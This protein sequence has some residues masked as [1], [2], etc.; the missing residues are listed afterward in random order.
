[1]RVLVCGGRD[2]NDTLMVYRTLDLIHRANMIDVLIEGNA[3]GADRMG[4]YW[5][6]KNRVDNLKFPA[7]WKAHGRAAGPIRN[8]KMLAEG[9]PDLV[10]AFPG[11]KGTADMKRQAIA[12]GVEVLEITDA[13]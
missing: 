9:E 1:L 5:A 6:R 11:G 12:A 10:V 4:G 3:S 8:M 13:L 7:D 2:F